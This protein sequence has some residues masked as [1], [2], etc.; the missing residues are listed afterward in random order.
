MA[1][2][3]IIKVHVLQTIPRYAYHA[4][5]TYDMVETHAKAFLDSKKGVCPTPVLPEDVPN[6]ELLI[7]NGLETIGQIKRF[8]DFTKIK[9]IGAAGAKALKE[10]LENFD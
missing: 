4:N 8:K 2:S 10:Y 1:K 9:G 5:Q 6:R 7:A 3:K